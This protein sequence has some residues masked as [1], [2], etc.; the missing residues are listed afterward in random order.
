MQST[1]RLTGGGLRGLFLAVG[2]T[3]CA[4]AATTLPELSD[5]QIEQY[6]ELQS[7]ARQALGSG[8]RNIQAASFMEQALAIHGGNEGDLYNLACAWGRAGRK[9]DALKSLDRALA[10]GFTDGEWAKKDP[11][12]KLLHGTPELEAWVGRAA[13]RE[14]EQERATAAPG[15][16]EPHPFEASTL[17]T[18]KA[19]LEAHVDAEKARAK[20][21]R[22]VVSPD[23]LSSFQRELD[24]WTVASWDRI[25]S[26]TEDDA[27]RADAALAALRV[28]AGKRPKY[29]REPMAT[30]ALERARAFLSDHAKS[31]GVAEVALMQAELRFGQAAR[32]EEEGAE[33]KAKGEY[34]HELLLLTAM[35]AAGEP[36]EKAFAK[37]VTLHGDDL[38]TARRLY[39]RLQ[40]L[41]PEGARDRLLAESAGMVYRLEG[42]P[43]FTATTIDGRSVSRADLNGKVTL[44][45]FW[46]TWCGPCVEELPNVKAAYEKFKGEGFDILG[47]SLDRGGEMTTAE[48]QK[49]CVDH[50]VGWAQI[51]DGKYFDADLAKLFH[52][53]GIPFG[54][55]IDRAGRVVAVEDDL[56]GDKLAEQI[57]ATLGQ[58]TQASR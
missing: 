37:L 7:K 54:L 24:Q 49:W 14:E 17:A 43:E 40:G 46:A 6:K 4:G 2:L 13:A 30:Q 27:V 45:E 16:G 48:F 39:E 47:I 42:L 1:V 53:T 18:S 58:A 3:V 50:G 51:Y 8:N 38:A 52:V 33:A 20:R 41:A 25:A 5:K 15:L 57:A 36:V 26:M 21:L 34:M 19:A 56:R 28:L 10:A 35:H 12:L 55:L 23:L 11:D 29:A 31:T 44:V 22:G 32:G 9:A